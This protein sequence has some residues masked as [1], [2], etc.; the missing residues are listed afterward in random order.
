[1]ALIDLLNNPE[2]F[3]LGQSSVYSAPGGSKK[4]KFST[5]QFGH[6]AN[7]HLTNRVKFFGDN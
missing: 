1:M 4:I 7:H 2:S 6:E 5:G 3:S